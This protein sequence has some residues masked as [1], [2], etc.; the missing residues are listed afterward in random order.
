MI[1]K[2]YYCD[3]EQGNIEVTFSKAE[4][5]RTGIIAQCDYRRICN[6]NYD[7]T[8]SLGVEGYEYFSVYKEINII[9]KYSELKN[10]LINWLKNQLIEETRDE[11][12]DFI[13]NVVKPITIISS[14]EIGRIYEVVDIENKVFKVEVYSDR[15]DYYLESKKVFTVNKSQSLSEINRCISDKEYEKEA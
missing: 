6:N 9:N 15:T 14:E 4:L 5:G 10:E 8:I 7:I 11:M 3:K 1:A 12:N 2:K 13:K